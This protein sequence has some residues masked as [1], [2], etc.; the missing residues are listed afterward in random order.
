MQQ[1]LWFQAC[2]ACNRLTNF[3][4][5]WPRSH[6]LRYFCLMAVIPLPSQDLDD[7]VCDQQHRSLHSGQGGDCRGSSSGGGGGNSSSNALGC[8][9]PATGVVLSPEGSCLAVT[10][11]EEV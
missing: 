8:S 6:A 2:H 4:S 5:L 10:L 7:A 11:G 1:A 9:K 3:L